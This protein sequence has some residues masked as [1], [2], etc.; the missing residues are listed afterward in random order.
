[1]N[2][3]IIKK[4]RDKTSSSPVSFQV[5]FRIVHSVIPFGGGSLWRYCCGWHPT[6]Q[7]LGTV[8]PRYRTFLPSP[9][10]LSGPCDKQRF[11]I[12]VVEAVTSSGTLG[13]MDHMNKSP[14]QTNRNFRFFLFS[15]SVWYVSQA[16]ILVTADCVT[17]LS[18]KH[19]YSVET[20]N[21]TL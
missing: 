13:H 9:V 14:E 20:Y 7:G 5:P 21:C 11:S 3:K 8:H 19:I 2:N 18:Y 4:I 12:L 15:Y 10:F 16:H 6:N 1:M 17:Y